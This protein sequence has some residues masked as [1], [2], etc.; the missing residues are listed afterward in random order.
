[1]TSASLNLLLCWQNGGE[2]KIPKI[3]LRGILDVQYEL[4]Y[5]LSFIELLRE[6]WIRFLP[7]F[8]TALPLEIHL[9]RFDVSFIHIFVL[10]LHILAKLL[11]FEG[12]VPLPW[13]S[14]YLSTTVCHT[15]QK[16]LVILA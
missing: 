13:F 3:I 11:E 4:G 8:G 6:V 14:F 2:L 16:L 7:C 1:M 15:P 10:A 5:V 9:S 12:P